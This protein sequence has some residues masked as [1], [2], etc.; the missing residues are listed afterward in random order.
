VRYTRRA[1]RA[2]AP[3]RLTRLRLARDWLASGRRNVTIC[4]R[5][6]ERPIVSSR[7]SEEEPFLRSEVGVPTRRG[8]RLR[9]AG[10]RGARLAS[11]RR[12]PRRGAARS[13][14]PT[15]RRAPARGRRP[16]RSAA[17]SGRR[18]GP[19]KRSAAHTSPN[20]ALRAAGRAPTRS[21]SRQAPKES[22]VPDQRIERGKERDGGRRLRWRFQ[23]LDVL[24]EDEAFAAHALDLDR[25]ELAEL[26]QLLA[27]RVSSR[28]L[29]ARLRVAEAAEDVSSAADNEQTVGTVPGQ[30]LVPEL[31]FQRQIARE[32]VGR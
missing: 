21:R 29:R 6:P 7:A 1:A 20:G 16:G 27:Q 14:S 32:P 26:D 23:Q 24:P 4:R 22:A 10:R 25:N 9:S 17:R 15:R 19:G 12:T 18:T 8:S 30:E 31:F 13:R 3:L 2:L 5:P 11:H 28:V